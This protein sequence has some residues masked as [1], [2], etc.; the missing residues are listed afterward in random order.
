VSTT[1]QG[2]GEFENVLCSPKEVPHLYK[3]RN[4]TK[5]SSKK[6]DVHLTT[7]NNRYRMY[8]KE[9]REIWYGTSGVDRRRSGTFEQRVFTSTLRTAVFI[10]LILICTFDKCV[11]Y[12]AHFPIYYEL[13]TT[14]FVF[15]A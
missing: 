4:L 15:S 2:E 8:N 3:T 12:L 13:Q 9:C 14:Q 7:K 1:L 11:N 6:S 5:H 10:I